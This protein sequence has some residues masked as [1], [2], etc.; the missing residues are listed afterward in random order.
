M[1]MV[2]GQYMCHICILYN[3]PTPMDTQR[4][5]ICTL[6][7][8]I[9]LQWV[10][11]LVRS[12]ALSHD[13]SNGKLLL[14][15]KYRGYFRVIFLPLEVEIVFLEHIHYTHCSAYKLPDYLILFHRRTKFTFVV[16]FKTFLLYSQRKTIPSRSFCPSK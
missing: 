14:V 7:P 4:H 10:G 12:H 16:F 6:N 2:D 13:A 15:N 5:A 9:T 8:C 3:I 1:V 11:Q